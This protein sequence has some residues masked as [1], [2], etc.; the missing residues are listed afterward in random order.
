MTVFLD[1]GIYVAFHNTRDLNHKRATQLITSILKGEF[2]AAYTS[3]YIFD[4]AVTVVLARTR[5]HDLALDLGNII[6]SNKK[7]ALTELIRVDHTI[8][9]E[10]WRIFQ[11]IPERNLS[12]TDCTTIAIVKNMRI[13]SVLSFDSDFDGLIS[14][15]E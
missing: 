9:Q 11:Q 8:F 6:L 13:D 15:I 12:F 2:G 14:R 5:R 3:D 10:A 4:E 7:P 1:T